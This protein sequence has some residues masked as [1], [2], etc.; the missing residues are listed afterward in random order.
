[1]G[2]VLSKLDPVVKRLGARG[3]CVDSKDHAHV[4]VVCL[5]AEEPLRGGGVHDF[6]REDGDLGRVGGDG[7]EARVD[8]GK[9]GGGVELLCAR[10]GKGG[11]GDGVIFAAEYEFD[12][13]SLLRCYLVG[14]KDGRESGLIPAHLNLENG[15]KSHGDEREK[16]GESIQHS[17]RLSGLIKRKG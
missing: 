9:I 7:H 12:A 13:V 15:S 5:V 6:D 4:A 11:L 2:G 10:L 17:E 1:M 3:G 8:T 14:S 16:K